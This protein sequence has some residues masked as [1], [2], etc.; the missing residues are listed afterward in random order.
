M[1]II[2]VKYNKENNLKGGIKLMAYQSCRGFQVF[3]Q[4]LKT[5]FDAVGN[6]NA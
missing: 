3:R 4:H 2:S 5:I 1:S 6:A